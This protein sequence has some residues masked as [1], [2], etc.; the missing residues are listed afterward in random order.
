M[1]MRKRSVYKRIGSS[2]SVGQVGDINR[3]IAISY[4]ITY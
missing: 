2:A 3:I 1:S 4:A